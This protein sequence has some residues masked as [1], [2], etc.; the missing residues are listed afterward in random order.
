LL[1]EVQSPDIRFT[2]S[3]YDN[4]LFVPD[5]CHK[6]I[7]Q[8]IE[9][10]LE[11]HQSEVENIEQLLEEAKELKEQITGHI[12]TSFTISNEDYKGLLRAISDKLI[13]LQEAVIDADINFIDNVSDFSAIEET[14]HR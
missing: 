11:A 10:M 8:K 5:G 7:D 1:S 6:E 4:W 2:K 13:E 3:I 14:F 12:T 9:A